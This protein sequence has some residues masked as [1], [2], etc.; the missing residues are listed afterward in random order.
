MFAFKILNL[1]KRF[2]QLCTYGRITLKGPKPGKLFLRQPAL[3]MDFTFTFRKAIIYCH[4][5][6]IV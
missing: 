3:T 5:S 4:E 2:M 1:T 6:Y